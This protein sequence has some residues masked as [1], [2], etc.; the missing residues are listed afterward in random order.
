MPAAAAV[1]LACDSAIRVGR[2]HV[3]LHANGALV[4]HS[5]APRAFAGRCEFPG[6]SPTAPRV[7]TALSHVH[8]ATDTIAVFT[9]R[10][11][12]NAL[13]TAPGGYSPSYDG[14]PTCGA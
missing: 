12:P 6:A 3:L 13:D 10:T 9:R 7:G 1:A 8:S 4:S 14:A 2:S 5:R 11:N